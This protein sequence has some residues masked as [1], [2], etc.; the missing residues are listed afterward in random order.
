MHAV[1]LYVFIKVRGQ[2]LGT[3]SL[4]LPCWIAYLYQYFYNGVFA[5][6]GAHL[7]CPTLG[8]PWSPHSRPARV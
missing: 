3:D 2:H 6:Y 7:Y 1:C 5:S 8:R 4:P